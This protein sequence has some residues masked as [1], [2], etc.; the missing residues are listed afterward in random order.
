MPK[1]LLLAA[2]VGLAL[3]IA[4]I[5]YYGASSV[6]DAV[7][8]VGWGAALVALV[9]AGETSGAGLAWWFVVPGAAGPLV[10]ICMLL[11]WLRE[12]INSLLPVAQVGGDLIGARL[13]TFWGV[14]GGAAGA[15]VVVDLFVQT[16]TQFFF[17]LIGLACLIQAGGD[18][19]IVRAAAIGLAILGPALIGFFV[20]QRFGGF[21]FVEQAML[22][23]AK[24]PKWAS[25][26]GIS[27]LNDRLQEIYRHPLG[28]AICFAI[29]FAIWF[30][31]VLE[32]YTALHFMGYPVDYR[33]ALVIESLGQAVRGAAFV[34]P[35]AIGVQ[36]GGF[37]ALCAVFGIPAPTA[38]ALSLVKRLP[39]IA[40]G[41]PGLMI[42]QG[43][44]GRQLLRATRN[45]P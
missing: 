24:D 4:L 43:I 32:V 1:S 9:R 31:G 36:E 39:E 40:L 45:S 29:H 14:P 7:T 28:L 17:T 8:A 3:V 20:A 27:S 2:L 16:V 18:T 26:G 15:S 35:G 10:R 25:L 44:E 33:T 23:L 37:I 34:V 21:R 41:I 42:W 13:L 12:A 38:I 22:R 19:G 30:F 6:F 11:R 5:A